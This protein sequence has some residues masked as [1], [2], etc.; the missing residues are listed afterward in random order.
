MKA[1][2]TQESWGIYGPFSNGTVEFFEV[3]AGV[4]GL[5]NPT[6]NIADVYTTIDDAFVIAAAPEM[7]VL[8]YHAR[9]IYKEVDR[10]NGLTARGREHMLELDALL[11][12]IDGEK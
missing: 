6:V 8:L 2:Q 9:L 4:D 11:A 12:R 3:N 7:L 5:D 10:L 1:K